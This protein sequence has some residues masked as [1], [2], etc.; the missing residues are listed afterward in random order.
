MP[1]FSGSRWM[2][3]IYVDVSS[4]RKARWFIISCFFFC[5]FG[6]ISIVWHSCY[7]YYCDILGRNRNLRGQLIHIRE[8][9]PERLLSEDNC[10]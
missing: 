7:E 2:Q 10:T 1:G 8:D 4:I 3:L 5:M 6:E 9:E